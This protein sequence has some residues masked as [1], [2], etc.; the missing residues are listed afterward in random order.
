MATIRAYRPDDLAA[1]YDICLTTGASGQD[2]SALHSDPE[3][4]GHIYAAPYGVLEPDRV[5]VAEG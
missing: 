5:L 3:L 4:V 2:A 1:L